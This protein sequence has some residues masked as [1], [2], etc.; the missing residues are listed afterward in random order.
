MSMRIAFLANSSAVA[1]TAL[2][3]LVERYGTVDPD[4]AEV[5]VALGGDGFMLDTCLLYTSAAA[6]EEDSGKRDCRCLRQKNN[7][8]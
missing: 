5:I 3:T 1:Q 8:Q 4:K 2:E 7:K 6:D